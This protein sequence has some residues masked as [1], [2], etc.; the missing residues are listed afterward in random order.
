MR[1]DPLFLLWQVE[2][3]SR[4]ACQRFRGQLADETSADAVF[5][6][7]VRAFPGGMETRWQEPHRIGDYFETVQV[8]PP[9]PGG[10]SFRLLFRRRPD[11]GPFWKDLMAWVLRE[12]GAPGVTT[13]LLYRG[14]TEPQAAEVGP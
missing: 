14:D 1:H 4:D 5:V 6:D 11:A 9:G 12:R 7:E 8:L 3:P 13:S 2:C 10:T